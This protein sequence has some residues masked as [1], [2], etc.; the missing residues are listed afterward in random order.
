MSD[1]VTEVYDPTLPAFT[2]ETLMDTVKEVDSETR[3]MMQAILRG[4]TPDWNE[5]TYSPK[6]RMKQ[7]IS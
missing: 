2:N 5:N 3:A 7:G 6:N 1:R 4:E